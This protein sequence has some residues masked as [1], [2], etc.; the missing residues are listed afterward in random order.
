MVELNDKIE[1]TIEEAIELRL[2]LE[3]YMRLE[4]NK[5]TTLTKYVRMRN[6]AS[7][8]LDPLRKAPFGKPENHDVIRAAVI[9]L[10]MENRE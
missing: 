5:P 3:A 1:L 10:E 4:Q 6:R 9:R 7:K 2:A 8:A